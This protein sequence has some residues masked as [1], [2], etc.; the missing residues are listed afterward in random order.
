[1]ISGRADDLAAAAALTAHNLASRGTPASRAF[2]SALLDP[3]RGA[4]LAAA[5]DVEARTP[6]I[7]LISNVTAAAIEAPVDAEYWWQQTRGTVRFGAGIEALVAR[8][9]DLFLEIGPSRVL[10]GL[11]RDSAL[12]AAW[13][14]TLA[15]RADPVRASRE[16]VAELYTR[17]V[18]V[19]WRGIYADRRPHASLPDVPGEIFADTRHWLDA[20]EPSAARATTQPAPE[21]APAAATTDDQGFIHEEIA[22]LTGHERAGFSLDTPFAELG[23]SSIEI[24][25]LWQAAFA[26]CPALEALADAVYATQRGSELVALLAA[27]PH[28][29]P[30]DAESASREVE[31]W[32]CPKLPTPRRRTPNAALA[33]EPGRALGGRVVVDSGHPFFF[34]HP[35]DHVPGVL[36]V[37]CVQQLAEAAWEMVS[38][39]APAAAVT[40]LRIGFEHWADVDEPLRI[41]AHS[42][43]RAG[44]ALRIAGAISGARRCA[45]FEVECTASPAVA[46][47]PETRHGAVAGTLPDLSLDRSLAHK[48]R[49]ENILI[50]PIS[51]VD[52]A[53][54]ATTRLLAPDHALADG[55]ATAHTATFLFEAARQLSTAIAHTSGGAELNRRFILMSAEIA[56]TRPAP[57][58]P[59]LILSIL[60]TDR[61]ATT[62]MDAMRVSRS[63]TRIAG[64][65]ALGELIVVAG[66]LDDAHYS[67]R[68]W[69][70]ENSP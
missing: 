62:L 51:S 70:E 6:R 57:R 1:M 40:R 38:P 41:E 58:G 5:A 69:G 29:T 12:A 60:S 46:A 66:I 31:L 13:V 27:A 63:H 48:V 52:G 28:P 49:P 9:V 55:E 23:M 21:S 34:D 25:E 17:G 50:G 7:T 65:E 3:M 59:A 54:S 8:G 61:I 18:D 22:R 14:P 36:L 20:P 10:C 15:L 43:R 19:D 32:V 11:G 42:L 2:H 44:P 47:A 33:L 53:H 37:E 56:L 4:F 39:G 45:H 68:R 26:R 16:A 35:Y 64:T 30:D 67:Q 24:V